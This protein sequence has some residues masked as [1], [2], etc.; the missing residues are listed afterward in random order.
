M[1]YVCTAAAR[2]AFYSEDA[3]SHIMIRRD[4]VFRRLMGT[5]GTIR[6]KFYGI[7]DARKR[8][9]YHQHDGRR[10]AIISLGAIN[11]APRI[12]RA[13]A[14][15][16]AVVLLACTGFALVFAIRNVT[17]THPVSKEVV[18]PKTTVPDAEAE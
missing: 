16:A 6:F 14:A 11:V 12:P 18:L 5:R 15:L 4:E 3:Y 13:L 9:L 1:E 17:A 10:F 8:F 7:V 2:G